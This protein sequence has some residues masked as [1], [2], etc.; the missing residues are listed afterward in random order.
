MG[1]ATVLGVKVLALELKH[2]A[3]SY[4]YWSWSLEYWSRSLEYLTLEPQKLSIS[5]QNHDNWRDIFWARSA[6]RRCATIFEKNEKPRLKRNMKMQSST[7]FSFWVEYLF[8]CIYAFMFYLL[9]KVLETSFAQIHSNQCIIYSTV[10]FWSQS[11]VC[12]MSIVIAP[13][14]KNHLKT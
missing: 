8:K 9:V 5:A 14:V 6:A 7:N 2:W 1:Y 13:L 11:L 10:H 12:N 4:K 3:W